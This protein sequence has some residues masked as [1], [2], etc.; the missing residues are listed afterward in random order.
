MN[1][2]P[3]SL[4]VGVIRGGSS[5]DYNTSLQSG[6]NIL[7]HL[8]EHNNLIDIFISKDGKWHMKGVERSPE[9]ILK[10]VDVIFNAL[11]GP[12][13]EDSEIQE[14]LNY[15][16][17]P[18]TSSEKYIST[19]T[20]NKWLMKEHVKRFGLK[21]PT[22]GI[23]Y[24]DD[25]L[26]EKAKYIFNSTMHPLIVKPTIGRSSKD[27]YTVSSFSDLISIIK[28]LL[29]NHVSVLIEEYINGKEATGIVIDNFRGQSTYILPTIETIYS[30]ENEYDGKICPGNFSQNE[31]KEIEKLSS[32]I[33]RNLGLRHYS[34]SNFIV[35]PRR[36]IYFLEVST[37]PI[38]TDDSSLSISLQSVGIGMKEFLHHV[39]SLVVNTSQ[40]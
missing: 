29:T 34:Q 31:K 1:T 7:K 16:K 9:R 2:L 12:Y 8:S 36:G 13:S 20:T 5:P 22:G 15:H 32:I 27:I 23:I 30:K 19:I 11:C 21:T 38:M 40:F 33:H 4:R 17:I 6:S 14:I 37:L 28:D 3:S 25:L 24:D 35:S 10:H 39:I 18:Y 26:T